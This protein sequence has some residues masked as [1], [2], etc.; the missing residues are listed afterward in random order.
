ME[1]FD[2]AQADLETAPW[3]LYAVGRE[4]RVHGV[5][6][7]AGKD[8]AGT[9]VVQKVDLDVSSEGDELQGRLRVHGQD[10]ASLLAV[11]VKTMGDL[12]RGLHRDLLPGKPLVLQPLLVQILPQFL[13]LNLQGLVA[14][15]PLLLHRALLRLRHELLLRGDDA[16]QHRRCTGRGRRILE[17]CH[18]ASCRV[19]GGLARGKAQHPAAIRR[20]HDLVVLAGRDVA[21]AQGLDALL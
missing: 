16:A 17:M 5:A 19:T 21:A 9:L 3:L 12:R 1:A 6:S 8:C 11:E 20:E 14:P 2:G 4:Q 10:V 13:D 15:L 18:L 7:R